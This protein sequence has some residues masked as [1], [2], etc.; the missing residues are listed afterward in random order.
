MLQRPSFDRTG[1]L[2]PLNDAVDRASKF[3]AI[4]EGVTVSLMDL[5]HCPMDEDPS[6]CAKVIKSWLNKEQ[7]LKSSDVARAM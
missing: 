3:G 7:V 6:Q 2:D 1:A 5:G 4:R